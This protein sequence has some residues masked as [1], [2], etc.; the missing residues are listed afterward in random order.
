MI[1]TD[2][3]KRRFYMDAPWR[4]KETVTQFAEAELVKKKRNNV[5]F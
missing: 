3:N 1:I 4:D 2:H 5:E